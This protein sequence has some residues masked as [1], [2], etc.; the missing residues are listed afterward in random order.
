MWAVG[1]YLL[2]QEIKL[3]WLQ[4]GRPWTGRGEVGGGGGRLSDL[5]TDQQGL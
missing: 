2:D 3:R 1:A 5:M 4:V